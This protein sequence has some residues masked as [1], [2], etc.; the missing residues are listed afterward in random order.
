MM[1]SACFSGVRTVALLSSRRARSRV[2]SLTPDTAI[3][4]RGIR[5]SLSGEVVARVAVHAA[6]GL[7]VLRADDST[8]A[9]PVGARLGGSQSAGFS[10]LRGMANWSHYAYGRAIPLPHREPG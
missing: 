10:R 7:R 5:R 4:L 3:G 2:R 1:S 8:A 6:P 9:A